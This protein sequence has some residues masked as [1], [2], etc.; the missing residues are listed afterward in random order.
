MVVNK[1]LDPGG[2]VAATMPIVALL[3]VDPVAAEVQ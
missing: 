1:A 3:T 2:T